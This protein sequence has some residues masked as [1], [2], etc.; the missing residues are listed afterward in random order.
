MAVDF[1]DGSILYDFRIHRTKICDIDF[2]R[3]GP[4]VNDMGE[5][6]WGSKR[7]KAPEEFVLGAPIDS[8][9]NVYTLGAI[10]FGLL[11][12]EMDH[13]YAKWEAGEALYGAALRAV[14]PERG[15]RY[16]SVVEFKR[17]WDEAR[18]GRW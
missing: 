10:I 9:T 7:S 8:V 3:L 12:G 6:F 18:L 4:S 1:Y 17:V 5:H 11:G 13:S 14:Q 15:R 16:A 2:Y